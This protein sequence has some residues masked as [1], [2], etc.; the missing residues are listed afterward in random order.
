MKVISYGDKQRHREKGPRSTRIRSGWRWARPPR[1]PRA[2]RHVGSFQKGQIRLGGAEQLGQVPRHRGQGSK[3]QGSWELGAWL[4]KTNTNLIFHHEDAPPLK[5]APLPLTPETC[6]VPL[7][8]LYPWGLPLSLFLYPGGWGLVL[9]RGCCWHR[10]DAES[11]ALR[12]TDVAAWRRGQGVAQA[13]GEAGGRAPGARGGTD[14]GVCPGQAVWIPG[15]CCF[16]RLLR[17]QNLHLP[18]LGPSKPAPQTP[19]HGSAR[20]H[21]PLGDAGCSLVRRH[22]SSAAPWSCRGG[23]GES[24][25]LPPEPSLGCGTRDPGP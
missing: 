3:P 13:A 6:W 23:T 5:I 1:G 18:R 12:S 11:P 14:P 20:T 15:R 7:R 17:L 8:G 10:F 4:S 2:G 24:W 25:P 9:F 21:G 22:L 16:Q 19:W